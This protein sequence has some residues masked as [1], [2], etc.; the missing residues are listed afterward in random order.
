MAG[1]ADTLRSDKPEPAECGDGCCCWWPI[2]A[3]LV[4][5]AI[6]AII[7]VAFSSPAPSP[8]PP[9]DPHDDYGK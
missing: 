3:F 7:V 8:N 1:L 6:L 4:F 9:C 2:I 5:L